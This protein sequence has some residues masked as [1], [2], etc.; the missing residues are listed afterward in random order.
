ML[1]TCQC[2]FRFWPKTQNAVLSVQWRW[3]DWRANVDRV[4][5]SH[6]NQVVE[7]DET[8]GP[9]S[10]SSKTRWIPLVIIKVKPFPWE[11]GS[12]SLSKSDLVVLSVFLTLGVS[13]NQLVVNLAV[14]QTAE[15]HHSTWTKVLPFI[16]EL[17]TCITDNIPIWR[18]S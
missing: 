1:S 6:G 15:V 5:H 2:C 10:E 4:D 7:E 8:R 18:R 13:D 12:E 9:V 16:Y 14:T 11:S 17:L 3:C